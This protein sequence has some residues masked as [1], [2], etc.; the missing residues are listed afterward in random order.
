MIALTV[1]EIQEK[2][3]VLVIGV[4]LCLLPRLLLFF[5]SI[6]RDQSIP[7]KDIGYAIS[8]IEL[9]ALAVFYT[10]FIASS[11]IAGEMEK[12]NLTFLLSL[13]FPRWKLWA[14]KLA[15]SSI[16]ILFIIGLYCVLNGS[17]FELKK[18]ISCSWDPAAFFLLSL[19]L[20][21]LSMV[22]LATVVSSKEM[23]ANGLA[24]LFLLLT[25]LF[26]GAISYFL[27][28]PMVGRTPM[29]MVLLWLS[30]YLGLSIVIFIRM[31]YFDSGKRARIIWRSTLAALPCLAA[32]LALLFF[33]DLTLPSGRP[34]WSASSTGE[35]GA[36]LLNVYHEMPGTL[37]SRGIYALGGRLMIL[38]AGEEKLIKVNDYGIKQATFTPGGDIDFQKIITPQVFG[39]ILGPRAACEFWRT[40]DRGKHR[41]RLY[42]TSL[43]H[44][45]SA[46]EGIFHT[47]DRTLLTFPTEVFDD[48]SRNPTMGFAL[49][50]GQGRLLKEQNFPVIKT[51]DYN[52]IEIHQG[53]EQFYVNC[54]GYVIERN[55]AGGGRH[56]KEQAISLYRFDPEQGSLEKLYENHDASWG[57]CGAISPDGKKQIVVA[58]S[59]QDSDKDRRKQLCIV[60]LRKKGEKTILLDTTLEIRQLLWTP[61]SDKI[62]AWLNSRR[63]YEPWPGESQLILI[64]TATGKNEI[65]FATER[66]EHLTDEGQWLNSMRYLT[67]SL[68]NRKTFDH[69]YLLIDA[70]SGKRKILHQDKGMSQAQLSPDLKA[71]A[72]LKMSHNAED[73][74][75]RDEYM[76]PRQDRLTLFIKNIASGEI[77]EVMT[78]D[79]LR[80]IRGNFSYDMHLQWRGND[81]LLVTRNPFE[82]HTFRE[83]GRKAVK[84][85]P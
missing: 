44:Y 35:K 77:H 85:Y 18:L 56:Y 65:I 64:D 67:L 73:F 43:E 72:F 59:G 42:T 13:P 1:K 12:K 63:D 60:D 23:S 30:F 34:S 76:N 79:D 55:P 68:Y 80:I 50:D 41:R 20:L 62:Y 84:L 49:L 25:A 78:F 2:K 38:R 8:F 16:S 75:N 17:L 36:M 33:M 81:E 82:V 61:K 31:D 47:K 27:N 15:A 74:L 46:Y 52:R 29:L 11:A 39:H 70:Q 7:L 57:R 53:G 9:L 28:W 14:A 51:S 54:S 83:G 3:A 66:D 6:S 4:I 24:F 71:L 21:V 19:P 26:A 48:S 58:F 37:A 32:G 22:F 69:Q 5:F 10:M 40:D 45:H